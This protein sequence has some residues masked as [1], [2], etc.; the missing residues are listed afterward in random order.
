MNPDPLIEGQTPIDD[1][2][3]LRIKGI[4]T[5]AELNAAE[6]ENIRKATIRYLASR[7]SRRL[8]RFDLPWAM[9]LHAEMFGDVWLWA[10][11]LRRHETNLGSTP[12]LIEMELH[13][14]F[15]DLA[16]WEASEMARLEQAVRLHHGAVR[17]H[18]FA[19]GNGRWSRMLANVWL[20]LHGEGLIEW[21]EST[22]G[23]ASTIR[24]EF[25]EAV[26][27]ADRGEFGK[28]LE[29]HARYRR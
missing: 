7:P 4:R 16:A 21:P 11:K 23:S 2:S 10:G 15:E 26:R 6:A 5:T 1:L 28:L 17:I 24:G 19:N 13:N 8:A 3:G 25:L 27:E 9:R 12:H 14:L 22:I 18:P 29:L 20:M